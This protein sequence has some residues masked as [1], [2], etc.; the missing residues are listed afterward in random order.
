M[1][2]IVC[3]QA[4]PFPAGV[5]RSVAAF[6][7]PVDPSV[8]MVMFAAGSGIAPMRGFIQECAIQIASGC[9]VGKTVLF[10]GCKSSEEDYLWANDDL[11]EWTKSGMVEVRPAFRH[12]G[13]KSY[14]QE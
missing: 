6:H 4:A 5:R 1:I 7:L 13:D 8:P 14:V 12:V 9:Q 11:K 2:I 3:L 10:Y